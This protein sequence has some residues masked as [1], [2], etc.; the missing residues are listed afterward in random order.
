SPEHRTCIDGSRAAVRGRRGDRLHS[1]ITS[2]TKIEIDCWW[3]VLFDKVSLYANPA[4]LRSSVANRTAGQKRP[5]SSGVDQ[6]LR[7]EALAIRVH[8]E[9]AVAMEVAHLMALTSIH[10]GFQ[11]GV[12]ERAVEIEAR[13]AGS[14]RFDGKV[15]R[16][17]IGEN[18]RSGNPRCTIHH[19]VIVAGQKL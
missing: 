8:R 6:G 11:A 5:S 9:W 16:C 2:F 1:A 10:T 12:P 3:G 4:L 14:R 18:A 7:R 19:F 17:T 15:Q 13:N